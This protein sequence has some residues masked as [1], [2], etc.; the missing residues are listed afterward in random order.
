MNAIFHLIILFAIPSLISVDKLTVALFSAVWAEQCEQIKTVLGELAKQPS[1]T[2]VQFVD[3]P[4]EELSE[5]S[6]KHQVKK[7]IKTIN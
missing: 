3:V 6:L 7:Q 1:F 2:N 4:A 5:V